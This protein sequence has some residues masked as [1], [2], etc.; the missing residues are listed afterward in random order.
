MKVAI[1]DDHLLIIS[2]LKNTFNALEGIEVC[3]TYTSGAELI[4]GLEETQPDVLLL[5]YHMPDQNG[6]QLAR[7]ITYHYPKV[8]ILALTGFDKPDLA[9][10]MLESGCMG[11]LVKTT[12]N[13][14]IIA[15][16]VMRVHNGH[17]YMDSSIRDK[18]ATSIRRNADA[19]QDAKPKLTNREVEILREIASE[20]S[21]VEIAAKLN[22]SKRTVENHRNSIMIKSGAKNTV[23]LIK[24]AIELKLI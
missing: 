18:Y 11:Y 9:T 3:G 20:L 15:D 7:Y 13:E 22:L 8:R 4:K 16:A 21:N 19:D 24:F 10:E 1:A 6:A 14:D 5:D 17:M 12:A 23:G 2:S